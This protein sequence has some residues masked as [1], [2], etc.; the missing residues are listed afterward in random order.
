MLTDEDMEQIT[1]EWLE[2]FLAPVT[3]A[4]LSNIDTIGRSMVTRVERVG[5]SNGIMKKNK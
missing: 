2:E 4:K 5:Q 1:K 3:N